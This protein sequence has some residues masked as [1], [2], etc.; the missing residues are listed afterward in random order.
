LCRELWGLGLTG[1]LPTELGTLTALTRLCVHALTYFA[2]THA[3][4]PG[5]GLS[6]AAAWGYRPLYSNGLTGTLPTE[7][8]TLTA[9][10]YLYVRRP[11][12]PRLCVC[13]VTG[14]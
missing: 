5:C 6:T 10:N 9:V 1:T 4:S 2:R 11:H 8:G 12:P 14:L 7:L 3:L 13:A